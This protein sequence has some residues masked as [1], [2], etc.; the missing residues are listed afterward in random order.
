MLRAFRR[1]RIVLVY[2]QGFNPKP[3]VQFG[4]ALSVGVESFGEYLDLWSFV[5][6]DEE[7][8]VAAINAALP[9]GLVVSALREMKGDAPGLSE[10]VR[11]AR[12]LVKLPA[13]LSPSQALAS[14]A[15]R[16]ALSA[17]RKKDGRAVDFPLHIWL[18]E[19]SA[20]DATSFRM[21]LGTGGDGASVRPDE[22][23]TVMFGD[24]AKDVRLVREDLAVLW[25]GRLVNPM[26]VEGAAVPVVQRAAG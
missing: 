17:H 26:F 8:G 16:D 2:S 15:A 21:V 12:Y 22:V 4:P 10:S 3:R 11:A 6:L 14:F 24:A 19:V 7:S 5:R 1:A 25:E 9:S 23:L 18:L 13:G 20:V